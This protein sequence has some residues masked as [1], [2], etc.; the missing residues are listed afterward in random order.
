MMPLADLPSL[1][2]FW[3][4]IVAP[5]G[6]DIVR[7]LIACIV[8]GLIVTVLLLNVAPYG[9]AA[10]ALQGVGGGKVASTF[11]GFC[12]D[13]WVTGMLQ[14]HFSDGGVVAVM[15]VITLAFTALSFIFKAN[16]RKAIKAA[17]AE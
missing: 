3:V 9:A 17:A 6:G 5:C 2:F 1:L 14:E 12:P 4:Y 11:L 8:A 7:C 15:I 16:R 10:S 13:M